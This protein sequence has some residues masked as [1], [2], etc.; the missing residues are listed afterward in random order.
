MDGAFA[1]IDDG[2]LSIV[3]NILTIFGKGSILDVLP[4]FWLHISMILVL[5]R[6]YI[7]WFNTLI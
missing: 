6:E 3:T 5:I 7:N 4:I 1:K 2:L